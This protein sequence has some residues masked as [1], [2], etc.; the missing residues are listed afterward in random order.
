MSVL[1]AF[2]PVISNLGDLTGNH[3]NQD[4]LSLGL[5]SPGGGKTGENISG[6]RTSDIN[7]SKDSRV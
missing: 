3:Y 5:A 2:S 4:E 7:R 1:F 6:S